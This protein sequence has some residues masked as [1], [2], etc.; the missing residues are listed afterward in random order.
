MLFFLFQNQ[1]KGQFKPIQ[2]LYYRGEVQRPNP[3][4]RPPGPTRSLTQNE[5]GIIIH[6]EKRYQDSQIF[7]VYPVYRYQL[8]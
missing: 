2:R 4:P 8:S 7:H 1:F 3:G 6:E 5:D